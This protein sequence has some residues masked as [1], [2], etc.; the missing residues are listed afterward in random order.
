MLF[1]VAIPMLAAASFF[2]FTVIMS[3]LP[4]KN[5]QPWTLPS[6]PTIPAMNTTTPSTTTPD[7]TTEPPPVNTAHI[8]FAKDWVYVDEQRLTGITS[9]LPAS[10]ERVTII[11]DQG[12]RNVPASSLPQGFLDDWHITPGAL[13]AMDNQ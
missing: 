6:I 3:L 5:G 7:A 2:V 12:G 11:C 10:G 13:K 1:L 4:A 8:P 9:V